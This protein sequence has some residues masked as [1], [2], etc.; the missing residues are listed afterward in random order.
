MKNFKKIITVG[1]LLGVTLCLSKTFTVNAAPGSETKT[2]DIFLE[3][4]KKQKYLNETVENH[5]VTIDKEIQK[6]KRQKA[7][8]FDKGLLDI[9]N[10]ILLDNR[11]LIEN[12]RNIC[13]IETG[14]D[15][16]QLSDLRNLTCI[17]THSYCYSNNYIN[18]KVNELEIKKN[19][20]LTPIIERIRH[21]QTSVKNYT[22]AIFEVSNS[23]LKIY[24]M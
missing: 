13:K 16:E 18:D 8:L 3:I 6:L 21:L 17:V 10:S 23:I 24:N 15:K 1:L 14:Q 20:E 4:Q 12:I 5:L 11:L 9:F 19:D 22:F 7:N 2:E